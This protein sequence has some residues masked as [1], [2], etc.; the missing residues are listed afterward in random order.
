M[1]MRDSL[2]DG[3]QRRKVVNVHGVSVDRFGE[4]SGLLAE[5]S[6]ALLQTRRYSLSGSFRRKRSAAPDEREAYSCLPVSHA[7]LTDGGGLTEVLGDG[8]A[9]IRQYRRCSVYHILLSLAQSWDLRY[10]I[11]HRHIDTTSMALV[12]YFSL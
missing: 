10:T 3:K 7:V 11:F 9:V 2:Y 8:Q 5:L 6:S 1:F 12:W 4:D